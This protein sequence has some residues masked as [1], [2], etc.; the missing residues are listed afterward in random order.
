MVNR[1]H[2]FLTGEIQVG[3]STI[4]QRA[5][6]ET[7]VIYDGFSTGFGETRN[8]NNKSLFMKRASLPDSG[9]EEN[10]IVQFED[11]I[12]QVRTQVIERLGTEILDRIRV[13][14]DCIV[15]DE[16][17]RFEGM[18]EKFKRRIMEVL[19]MET[20]V[21]GVVRKGFEG[22]WLDLVKQHKDVELLEVTR[23]NREEIFREV[24]EFLL[25]SRNKRL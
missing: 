22:T 11:G 12:P 19:D 9:K 13:D 7:G 20:P 24:K 1:R 6:E 8:M 18:A 16:C 5:L 2:L 23:E 25:Q 15:M 10:V 14:A 17:G 21:V 3:K 4:I